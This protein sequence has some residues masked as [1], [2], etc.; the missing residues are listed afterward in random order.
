[1]PLFLF[2][3]VSLFFSIELHGT[4]KK[5][6]GIFLYQVEGSKPWDPDSIQSGIHGSE[7]SVIY[8]SQQLAKLGYR[9]LVF[10]HP[11]ENSRHSAADANPRFVK[12]HFYDGKLDIAIS[13]RMPEA[14]ERLKSR[15][16]KVYFWPHDTC[17]YVLKREHINA[18]DDVLWLSHW[19]REQWISMNPG[20][21]KFTKIFGNGI[22]V[23]QFQPIKERTNPHSCIYGS[24]Y[25]RGLEILLDLWPTVKKEFPDA[26]LDIYYGWK[27]WGLIS[28]EKESKMRAQIAYLQPFGVH[29][30]GVVG[31][32]ELNRAYENAS[33]WAYPCIGWET[34]CITALRAQMAGTLPVVIDGTALTETVRSGLKCSTREAYCDKLLEAMRYAEKLQV[35][36]RKKMGRF[37]LEEFTWEKIA[38]KWKELFESNA[39]LI[40]SADSQ[41]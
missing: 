20:F 19:Q 25:A 5:S 1:M 30:H 14:A 40:S 6:I 13:W 27:H 41:F 37:I 3:F 39:S 29:D 33:I 18:F 15:A 31:H 16:L 34:F 36:D 28:P 8:M 7:E 17:T 35:E 10:G 24:N 32:E 38:T 21:A 9:V 22:N 2:F 4:Q 26:T 12:P 11:P 23:D